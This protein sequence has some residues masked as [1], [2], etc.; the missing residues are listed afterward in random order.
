LAGLEDLDLDYVLFGRVVAALDQVALGGY[1]GTLEVSERRLVH[2][3]L[4]ELMPAE[5]AG[6][7]AV[8]GWCF[9]LHDG[10]GHG[11]D[12][13]HRHEPVVFPHLGHAHLGAEDAFHSYRPPTVLIS[14]STPV[15]RSRCISESIVLLVGDLM[16]MSRLCV[17]I[18]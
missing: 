12:D 14:M 11:E 2:P 13:G 10:A 17:R 15:G 9:A 5:L 7:V 8:G 16:S 4:L 1:A 6:R 3:L 18:S